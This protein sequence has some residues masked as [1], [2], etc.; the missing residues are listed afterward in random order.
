MKTYEQRLFHF[1]FVAVFRLKLSGS[2]RN[3]RR[4]K[5]QDTND[6]FRENSSTKLFYQKN[7]PSSK[8]LTGCSPKGLEEENTLNHQPLMAVEQI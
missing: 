6:Y 7:S 8:S 4:Y 1:F 2:Q 3:G 5:P